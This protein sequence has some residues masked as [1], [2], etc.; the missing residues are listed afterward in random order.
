MRQ[1]LFLLIS[2]AFYCQFSFAQVTTDP[3]FP[4]STEPITITF[5]SSEDIK[6]GY[7]TSE[8]YVHT[9]VLIEGNSEWQHVIGS[10]GNN[11]TQPRLINLGNGI[12]ELEITPDIN[13][14]YSIQDNEIVTQL[15]FVFRSSD[16]SQ[17]SNDLFI[18]IYENEFVINIS[19]HI[20]QQMIALGEENAISA[21]CSSD[22]SLVLKINETTLIEDSGTEI[23]VNH[24]FDESG[25]QWLI[26]EATFEG[27]LAYDSVLVYVTKEQI[28]E[29]K[30]TSYKQGINYLS[31][32]SVALVL[33]APEKNYVYVIGDFNNWQPNSNYQMKKDGD[34]FWLT[35][36]NLVPQK[37]Y[38]FQYF[39]DGSIKIGDTYSDKISDPYD[40]IYITD[41]IYPNLINYPSDK[42][43]GRASVLQT[44]QTEYQWQ[45]TDYS[46]PEKEN[47]HIY[48]LLIRDFTEEKSYQGVLDKLDYLERLG[49]NTIEL[50]PFNEFEGNSSWGYNP[51]YYFAPDKAYGTKDDLKELIDSCHRRGFIVIQDIVLNH[52]YGSNP[53]VMMYWDATNNRPAE[54]NPW[55]NTSSPNTNYSWGFDFNH[56]SSYTQLFV[57]SVTS[58]WMTE[59][60]IDGFRFDFTKGFTNTIGD[61]SAYDTSR[62]NILERMADHIW[63]VNPDAYI[64]LEHFSENTEEQILT[65]YQN[66]MLV[67][68]NANYSFNEATMGFT[69]NS[70]FSWASW[71][72]R[73]FSESGLV[74]YMESHDEE[75]LMYKN[76]TYGN[77]EGDYDITEMNTALQRNELAAAFFFC[78]TG[79][80]MIWQF[81][82]FGYDVSIDNNGRTG[83]K[84]LEWEYME[85][86]DHQKL[87]DVYSAMLRLRDEYPVFTSG[88]ETLKLNGNLKTIQLA[89]GDHYITLIGNFGMTEQTISAPFQHSGTWYEFFQSS[90]YNATATNMSITLA[91]G[92]YRLYSDQQLPEFSTLATNISDNISQ[93]KELLIFP[94]PAHHSIQIKSNDRIQN[95]NIFSLDGILLKQVQTDQ[96]EIS[97]NV[98]TFNNGLYLLQIRTTENTYNQKF[99]KY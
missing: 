13:S 10:W 91:A 70:D 80:K 16:G 42:T 60:K 21:S 90:T 39:I 35:I 12:Y 18:E 57:D 49:I 56:E 78:L 2:I 26:S 98:S 53:M 48:E 20:D 41:N 89:F 64:I 5:N 76:L 32:D 62:I 29:T 55:F 95:I 37:E 75:R 4:I 27:Q 38:V 45:T 19:S 65:N 52:A 83:E 61:G 72:M 73:N 31:D 7:F 87:F 9:G 93:K 69:T 71:Q 43:E 40:D 28:T 79:P 44:G 25:W 85:D 22:A 77:S 50:M 46:I 82:E 58:Y 47:L 74:A 81:G 99:I 84:P 11:T 96:S 59:Y 3:T 33:W 67:W 68:G 14:Y 17:Q 8:L 66:G 92:E 23:S 54:N 6:L 86:P 36:Q 94:N 88:T 51:N 24:K 30:P 15:A 1:I 34:Y 97:I 63:T